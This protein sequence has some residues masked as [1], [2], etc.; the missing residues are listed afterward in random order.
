MEF[1]RKY[2]IRDGVAYLV[3]LESRTDTRI[4]GRADLHIDYANFQKQDVE[5]PVEEARGTSAGAASTAH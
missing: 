1:V 4:V 2:D 5:E 3:Q